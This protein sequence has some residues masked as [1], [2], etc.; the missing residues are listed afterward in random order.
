MHAANAFATRPLQTLQ[1]D[2]ETADPMT[3]QII[4]SLAQKTME[5]A[6]AD[7]TARDES[8]LELYLMVLE[9]LKN[10]PK[11]IETVANYDSGSCMPASVIARNIILDHVPCLIHVRQT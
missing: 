10:I 5:K 7:G 4:L 3:F 1:N 2:L 11:A 8:A 9:L 6:L